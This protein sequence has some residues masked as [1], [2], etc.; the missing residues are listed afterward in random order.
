MRACY[1]TSI[2]A[3]I[4]YD[5]FFLH[6]PLAASGIIAG[7]TTRAFAGTAVPDD[8]GRIGQ[9]LGL[10][11]ASCVYLTQVHGNRVHEV[12]GTAGFPREGDGLMTQQKNIFLVIRTA[13]CAPVF[14]IN[15]KTR[16][17]CLL[18]AG[19]RS[20]RARIVPYALA[21]FSA[22]R[23]EEEN[24]Y[25]LIGPHLRKECFEVTEEFCRETLFTEWISGKNGRLTFDLTGFIIRE[26]TEAGISPGHITD[27]GFCSVCKNDLFYSYRTEQQ[28]PQRTLSFMGIS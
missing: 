1:N 7:F 21:S 4:R 14:I 12:T 17:G 10:P 27:C 11:S 24:I 2:M 19:W 15:K 18:H 8:I 3:F 28:P 23:K 9:T 13:D 5:S 16:A 6:E 22:F 26:L 20:A 25:A